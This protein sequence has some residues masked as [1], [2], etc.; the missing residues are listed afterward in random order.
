MSQTDIALVRRAWDAFARGDV[1]AA[2]EAFHP[3]VRWHGAGEPDG[4]GACHNRQDAE[5][6]LRGLLARGV[7]AELLDI[8]QAGRRLVALVQMRH[9]ASEDDQPPPHGE[10]ITV[11]DGKVTEMLSYPTLQDAQAAGSAAGG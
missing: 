11:R 10:L 1:D 8:R 7:S 6:F 2:V 3:Q 5:A 9:A 4:E